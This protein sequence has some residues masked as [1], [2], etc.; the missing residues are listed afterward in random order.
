M[1]KQIQAQINNGLDETQRRISEALNAQ[2]PVDSIK[3]YEN[4]IRQ[5]SSITE[6]QLQEESQDM[7]NFRKSLIYQDLINRGYTQQ[8]AEKEVKKSLDAG[9]DIDDAIDALYSNIEFYKN[10]YAAQVN[11][12]KARQ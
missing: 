7:E 2:V 5:L 1:I 3:M 8:K 12:N 4:T 11:S 10:Q 9:T 6:E